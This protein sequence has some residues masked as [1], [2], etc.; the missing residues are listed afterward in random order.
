MNG[1]ILSIEKEEL[2]SMIRDAVEAALSSLGLKT[3]PQEQEDL[4]TIEDVA[5]WLDMKKSALYQK[6]HYREIPFMKKGKRVYFSRKELIKWLQEGKK[7]TLSE[8]NELA[9]DRL[10]ELHEKRF[11]PKFK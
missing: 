1:V 7:L 5:L 3:E 9:S 10:V 11:K 6:T 4:M 2:A 8:R